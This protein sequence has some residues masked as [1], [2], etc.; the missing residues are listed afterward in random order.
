MKISKNSNIEITKENIE[1]FQD[2]LKNPIRNKIRYGKIPKN[3]KAKSPTEQYYMIVNNIDKIPKC[4]C[5][6]ELKFLGINQGYRKFCSNK[7]SKLSL[8]TNEKYLLTMK[9]KYGVTTPFLLPGV[10]EKSENTKYKKYGNK[11]F[12]NRNKYKQT[13]LEKYGCNCNLAIKEVKEKIR[14]TNELSG[15]WTP[16]K[17]KSNFEIYKKLVWK[18]TNKNNLKLLKNFEKRGRVDLSPNAYHLDHIIS[19]KYGFE[20]NILPIYLGNKYNLQFIEWIN[21]LKK[22]D[23]VINEKWR[24]NLIWVHLFSK[25]NLTPKDF[26]KR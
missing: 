18:Y 4:Y 13:C 25:L 8:E 2:F 14:K 21:N 9:E 22:S 16:L 11:Y 26:T 20:N 23:K 15:K 17:N 1:L 12:S 7:C 5:G 24:L 6:K 10:K 3:S 19:I